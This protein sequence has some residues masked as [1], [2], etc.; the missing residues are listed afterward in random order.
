MAFWGAPIRPQILPES[1]ACAAAL[2]IQDRFRELRAR[3]ESEG[4][5]VFEARIGIH[6]GDALVGNIGSQ[7]RMNYTAMGDTVNV[8]RRLEGLTRRYETGILVG[9]ATFE[10]ARGEFEFRLIDWVAVKGRK[11]ALAIYELLAPRRTLDEPTR[12]LRAVYTEGLRRYRERDWSGAREQFALGLEREPADGPCRVLLSR[13]D[14]YLRTPPPV[15]WN[16]VTS[17]DG[18]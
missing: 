5:V 16:G 9:A 3:R 14:E 18:K 15:D 6:T 4:R 8:A 12:D 10:A 1:H 2:E 7:R 17:L 13:C 11:G